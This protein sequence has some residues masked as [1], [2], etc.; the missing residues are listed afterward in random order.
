MQISKIKKVGKE[1]R[2]GEEKVVPRK[3]LDPHSLTE[4]RILSSLFN[5]S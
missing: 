5:V 4:K 2:V 1:S 3:G